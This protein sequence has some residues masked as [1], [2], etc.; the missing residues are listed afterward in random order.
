MT[1]IA[2]SAV[3]TTT[4]STR[5]SYFKISGQSAHE[6]YSSLMSHA[7][8]PGGHDAYATTSTK[9][10]QNAQYSIG[11]T[12]RIKNYQM[13]LAFNINLPQL[14]SGRKPPLSMRGNWK[15]FAD[16]LKVHEEHH[17]SLWLGCANAFSQLAQKLEASNCQ[18]LKTNYTQL[19]VTMQNSCKRQNDAFDQAERIRFMK[20]PFIQQV[21]STR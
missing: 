14:A 15:N 10:S 13:N 3:A 7:K 20:I 12:C 16:V 18:V 2:G 6:V 11:K 4:N 5:Y 9:I 1:M 8:G 21:L 17:R 19:W